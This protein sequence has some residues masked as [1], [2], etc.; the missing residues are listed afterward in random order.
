MANSDNAN[1]PIVV[2]G[3]INRDLVL[4][5]GPLPRP[6]QTVLAEA[7][8]EFGGGKGANQAVAAARAGARVRMVG[9]VGD[10][11]VGQ[12]LVGQL[13]HEGIDCQGVSQIANTPTGLAVITVGDEGENTIVLV[14]GANG[15]LGLKLIEQAKP[16]IAQAHTLLVQ[17]E[18][19]VESALAGMN[20][21]REHR[22]RV[23]LDPAPAPRE[24]SDELLE[25]DLLCPNQTEAET[26]TGLPVQSVEQA[27]AAAAQ[28][29]R[30]GARRVAITLGAD[31]TLLWM[32]D[33]A[34]HVPPFAVQA[35][36]A[37]AAGDAF[38][39]AVAASWADTDDL[40]VA[41]AFG[42]AAGALA[43]SSPGAQSS[44]PGMR[45]IQG[46]LGSD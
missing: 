23:I 8:T 39:G 4:S 45:E 35:V 12:Q 33:R 10:D 43:A 29:C 13:E 32:D 41:V 16:I 19:P 24:V 25:V 22:V 1:G 31:G 27:E 20:W 30:R 38:A 26:L 28:L 36:D 14:P 15:A 21:A 2:L 3:S 6:G 34:I 5:G 11:G 7:V 42:N 37:T 17:L 40:V 46:L 9:A 18:V 44:L